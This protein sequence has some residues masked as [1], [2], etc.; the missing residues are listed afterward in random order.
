MGSHDMKAVAVVNGDADTIAIWH[1]A[2]EP[3]TQ[4]ARLCGA[5]VTNDRGVQQNVIASRKVVLLAHESNESWQALLAHAYGVIDLEATTGAV[6]HYT[7]NLDEKHRS[8][9]TPKGTSR[10]PI[11]WPAVPQVPDWSSTPPVP[12]GVVKDTLIRSTIA[13][14]RWFASL[15][16]TWSAIETIRASRPHLSTSNSAPL[17]LPLVVAKD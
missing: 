6:A 9:L 8:N 12:V 14:A 11:A 15:A 16:D 4:T 10:A 13:V 1:V 7:D 5:W 3:V 2:T 17:P